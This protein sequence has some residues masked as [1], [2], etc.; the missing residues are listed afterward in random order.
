MVVFESNTKVWK[1]VPFSILGKSTCPL[2][3]QSGARPDG[4]LG[5]P[6]NALRAGVT[7]QPPAVDQGHDNYRRRER[8]RSKTPEWWQMRESRKP[9]EEQLAE[10]ER[11]RKR[12]EDRQRR[13]QEQERKY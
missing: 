1:S 10:Q 13:E 2:R 9:V 6:V 7:S 5:Q 3:P 4:T 8:S 11:E 12:R